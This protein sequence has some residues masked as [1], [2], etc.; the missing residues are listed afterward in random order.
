[1]PIARDYRPIQFEPC[2]SVDWLFP[3]RRADEDSVKYFYKMPS[4]EL[5]RHAAYLESLQWL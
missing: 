3:I 1:M 4:N 5:Y 2:A